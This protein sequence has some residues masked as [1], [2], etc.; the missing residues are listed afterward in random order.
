MIEECK[1][2][3]GNERKPGKLHW[4]GDRIYFEFGFWKPLN[5]EIKK[6]EGR[7]YHGY[8]KVNPKKWWSIPVTARNLF[9]LAY[10]KELNPYARYDAQLVDVH[11]GRS[12]YKHQVEMMR[13]GL[14]R[15]YAIWACEMGTGKT[16]AA[17]SLIEAVIPPPAKIVNPYWAEP[18]VW[19]IGPKSALA[20]VKYEFQKWKCLVRPNF[21]TYEGLVKAMNQWVD[22][23]KAPRIVIFDESSRLKTPTAQR[24]QAGL[25]LADG[26]RKDWGDDG[27]VILMSGSPAPKSPAD[28]W[29][30]CEVACP[31]FLVE[32]NI[33]T[34]SQRLG[35]IHERENQVTGGKYPHLVGWRDSENKCDTCGEQRE[36]ENHDA[37]LLP[38][39]WHPFKPCK[40]EVAHL[41]KRMQGLV[42]V[43][44]KKDCLDLPE[45]RYV[46]L[47]ITPT[48]STMRAAKT[49]AELAPTAIK[50]LILLRELSDGF[51]YIDV[52]DGT[53]V[54]EHCHGSLKVTNYIEQ[55]EGPAKELL[56]DCPTCGG[57]GETPKIVRG[58]K[59]V[60]CPKDDK[61]REQLELHEEI[62]RLVVYAGFTGSID[63]I[64]KI[65]IDEGWAVLR[66]DGRGWQMFAE[67][68]TTEYIKAFQEM[69]EQYPRLVFVGHPGSAGM[70]LTLTASPT[71]VYFS[72]D[73]SGEARIQSEDRIHRPG[74]DA[75]RGATIIDFIHLPTDAQILENLRKKREL[76]SISLGELNEV[77]E[78][79]TT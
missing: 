68:P 10:L 4:V 56:V 48:P 61:L 50:A 65:C 42:L 47:E 27:Y 16:L 64:T 29:N 32:G 7:K 58:I 79:K 2:R 22:G 38:E 71:I 66:V 53:Q 46:T 63:R 72:N 1:L 21:I 51:Q 23:T 39:G 8:D 60:P 41:Y 5:E 55:D 11:T 12:L 3:V 67:N 24:S 14:T 44:F 6:M 19:W 36:H 20:A 28:W 74:M 57:A 17:I 33:H 69:F 59:E 77:L 62:G 9:Q 15:H 34:F 26:V 25:A 49:I 18:L 76:Q 30:Q 31:G 40:N 52:Q 37:E 35:I 43:Q 13:H 45:K 70:G 75:N 78:S 54:C 73:F